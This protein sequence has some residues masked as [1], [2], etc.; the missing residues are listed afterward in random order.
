MRLSAG[1]SFLAAMAAAILLL[2][3]DV[4]SAQQNTGGCSIEQIGGTSRHLL[5]CNNGLSAIAEAGA[6]YV[7]LDRNRDDS[8]DAVRLTNR[9]LLLEVEQPQAGPQIEVIAPQAIAAVR[10]TKWAVDVQAN[11]TS[12]FVVRGSVAV[13]RSSGANEV[14]LGAGDGVDV[15]AGTGPLVVRQWPAARVAAL[16]ARFGQ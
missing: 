14:V 8:A 10:G 7:V 13:R 9:A 4:A 6:S 15:E 11:R 2:G 1:V 16:L 5:R 3:V 12:V